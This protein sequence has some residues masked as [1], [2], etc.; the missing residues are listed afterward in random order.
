MKQQADPIGDLNDRFIVGEARRVSAIVLGWGSHGTLRRRDRDVLGL[1]CQSPAELQALR[2]SKD[3]VPWHPLYLPYDATPEPF[4]WK[5]DPNQPT[6][7]IEAD[8]RTSEVS[9]C[10]DQLDRGISD[11]VPASLF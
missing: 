2:V 9:A 10:L 6:R 5:P 11:W 8:E 3:G 7:E 1:L 4:A